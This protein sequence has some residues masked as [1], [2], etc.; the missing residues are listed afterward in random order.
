MPL[1]TA[2][3]L[4][5][6][7]GLLS[8]FGGAFVWTAGAAAFVIWWCGRTGRERLALLAVTVAG[9]AMATAARRED[10]SCVAKL[11]AAREWRVTLGADASPGAFVLARAECGATVRI[12]VANGEA[13]AGATV[14]IRGEATRARGGLLAGNADVRVVRAAGMLARW[15]SAIGAGIDAR[16]GSDA[17]LVRALLIADM[18]DLSPTLRDRFAAAG[19]S[20]MLSVSGLHVGL[21]AVAVS[22][23]AQV[24]GLSRRRADTLVISLTAGYVA[25]IGAPLPAVRA[26]AMLGAV[27]LGRAAQRPTSAWAVL[28][29]GAALPL[30]DPRA[31]LDLG[32]RLSVM[33][34]VALIAAAALSKRWSLLSAGGWRGTLYRSVVASAAATLLTA[35]LVAATFGRI[36]LV[37]PLSNLV[38]VPLM[39]VLQPMLFLFMLLLP[40]QGASQFVAD[41]CH[42]LIVGID[43]I[44]FAAAALPGASLPV[45]TDETTFLFASLAALAFVVAAASRFPG[46]ALL[47]GGACLVAVAWRPLL[48][49]HAGLTELHMLDVGQGDAVALRTASGR[50]VLFDAGREWRG[51]D[52]GQRSVVPYIASRGGALVA[53]VLSHPHA[54]HVGGAASTLRALRPGMY[55]DPGYAGGSTPYRASLL[56]AQRT[57][58]DW[59]RVRPGDSLVVDEATITFLAPD[60]AWAESQRDPNLASAVARVRVGAV[61]MLLTGDAEAGEED[62]LLAHQP[63]RL[64][65]DVLKV[66]HHGSKTSSSTGFLDAV[67]PRLALVSVGAGNTYGHPSAGVLRALAARGALTLRT[68]RHGT[69]VVRTDGQRIEVEARGET[70][71]LGSR[72]PVRSR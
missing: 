11:L 63:G 6:A 70:W 34:M 18:N 46:R 29:V 54:D 56:E 20:H 17:P 50:W 65:S 19:L 66:A 57:H 23:M 55:F 45:V 64:E 72:S 1:V 40:V 39:G 60:S 27:S 58:A 30:L 71:S 38:A 9:F 28:A 53:F 51:G 42:P 67:R 33:G 10:V 32:Y 2:T 21:I 16:F 52:E 26:G 31:V 15:R 35:P 49:R 36:S 68:D 13:P 8:G 22:L 7:A 61:T 44:A 41:A 24:A 14:A 3:I 47:A 12:A 5:Y 59:Q 25:V 4:V 37:A 48:P 43:R 69:I 62:W